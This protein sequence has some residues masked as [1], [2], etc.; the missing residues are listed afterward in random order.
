M[1]FMEDLLRQHM[2]TMQGI[3]QEGR[4]WQTEQAGLMTGKIK[5]MLHRTEAVKDAIVEQI[6][7]KPVQAEDIH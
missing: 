7:G 5:Q 3:T 2:Q 6:T 4:D 1:T